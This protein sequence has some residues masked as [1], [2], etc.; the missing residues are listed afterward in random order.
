MVSVLIVIGGV[1]IFVLSMYISKKIKQLNKYKAQQ[2]NMLDEQQKKLKERQEY[3]CSSIDIIIKALATEQIEVIEASIRLKVLIDQLQPT[4]QNANFT[5]IQAVY[6]KT[7]HIPRLK[8][9]KALARKQRRKFE[10][11]MA[12]LEKEYAKSVYQEAD[13]L[14][15]AMA[16]R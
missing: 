11:E 12:D 13:A 3:I 1:A 2:Q 9:W 16:N 14:K 7:Q 4:L 8:E 10:V 6:E 15:E 5:A